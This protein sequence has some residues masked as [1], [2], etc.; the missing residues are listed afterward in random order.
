MDYADLNPCNPW[1]IQTSAY[2]LRPGKFAGIIDD[3]ICSTGTVSRSEKDLYKDFTRA[4]NP[5]IPE[6][7]GRE[8]GLLR[9]EGLANGIRIPLS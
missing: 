6:G 3:G 4:R 9:E 2:Q 5:C 8:S 7:K 1:F